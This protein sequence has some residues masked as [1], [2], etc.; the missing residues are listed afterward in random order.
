MVLSR[1]RDVL[2]ALEAHYRVAQRPADVAKLLSRLDGSTVPRREVP[3]GRGRA[4][5]RRARRVV[6]NEPHPA[7]DRIARAFLELARSRDEL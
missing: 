2:D 5:T 4:A 6:G 3:T 7:S 1:E